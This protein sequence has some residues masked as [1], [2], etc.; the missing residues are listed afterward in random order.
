MKRIKRKITSKI[1]ILPRRDRWS[2]RLESC[3]YSYSLIQRPNRPCRLKILARS[4]EFIPRMW[5]PEA[6]SIHRLLA[7]ADVALELRPLPATGVT[8]FHRYY[9]PVRHPRRPGLSLAE[10]GNENWEVVEFFEFRIS[11]WRLGRAGINRKT[12]PCA[13]SC[14]FF[15]NPSGPADGSP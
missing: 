1:S 13:K 6:S 10:R 12:D 2:R 8:R 4:E 5:V 11:K 14:L 3:S 9:E 7:T 15:L